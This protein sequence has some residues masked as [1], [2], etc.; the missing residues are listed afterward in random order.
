M[1]TV[2]VVAEP[3]NGDDVRIDLVF[4]HGLSDD[5]Q[6]TWK[7]DGLSWIQDF[8]PKDIPHA[9]IFTCGFNTQRGSQKDSSHSLRGLEE[10][11]RRRD[12]K[13]RPVI[14]LAHSLGGLIL[15]A[16]LQSCTLLLQTSTKGIMFFSTP[17]SIQQEDQRTR[18]AS[19]MGSIDYTFD[20]GY[21]AYLGSISEGFS[22]WLDDRP[23]TG[24]VVCFYERLPITDDLMVVQKESAVLPRCEARG[25]HANHM[26][27]SQFP[28]AS[29][30][31]YQIVLQCMKSMYCLADE[32]MR[33]LL[34]HSLQA[35]PHCRLSKLPTTPDGCEEVI[36]STQ[37][38]PAVRDI[39]RL[40]LIAE[41]QGHYKKAEEKY[42]AAVNSLRSEG[43]CSHAVGDLGGLAVAHGER[44]LDVEIEKK[45]VRLWKLLRS[46]ELPGRDDAAI[47]FCLNKWAC[48]MYGRGR[49]RHAELY[50]RYCLEARIKLYGK[51]SNS[52]LLATANWVSSMMSLGRYQEACNTIRDALENSD[53]TFLNNVSS[54]QVLETFAKL[55]SEC[56]RHELAESILCDVLRKAI[57]LYGYEHPFTLNR[58]SELAAILAHKGNLS[59]AEALSRRCLDGLEQTLGNDH[60]DCLR[61]A[62]RLADYICLQQRY[63]DAIERHKQILTKQRMRIGNQ[64]PETLLTMRSLGI[65]FAL[66]RYWKDAE[67]ILDRALCDLEARLGSDNK[68]TVWAAR[69]LRSVKELHGGQALKEGVMQTDLLKVFG[70]QPNPNPDHEFS[71][72]TYGLS[73]FQTSVEDEVLR[74]VMDRNE[75]KL[76]GVLVKQTTNRQILGRA[77]REAAASSHEPILKLLLGFDAPVNEQSGYH[78]SA[79]QAASLAGSGAIVKLLLGHDADVNQ[80]G[81]IL[82]NALR[83]AVFGGHEAILC[84]LLGSAPPSGLSQNV[85]NTSIQLALRTEN[86][87]MIDHLIEAGADLNAE[88]KLFGSPL[89]QASFYGQK[90]I[91]K[92][93]LERKSDIN[94]RAGL[95]ASPLQVAIETQNEWAINQLLEAG[96]D[97]SSNSEEIS[98]DGHIPINRQEELAKILLNRLADSLPYRPLSVISGSYDRIQIS[99]SWTGPEPRSGTHH[100]SESPSPVPM[101]SGKAL[102]PRRVSTMKRIFEFKSGGNADGPTKAQSMKKGLMMKPKRTFQSLRRR[103]SM[104]A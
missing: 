20:D 86:K 27:M 62:R 93:L 88:D 94:M 1:R 89:Q 53:L 65:D 24:R 97:I 38:T 10:Y 71:N 59:S 31:N 67:M 19:V 57:H 48:L 16:F 25:L 8:V 5:W 75:E 95:L 12:H 47:L 17:N 99:T 37:G 45:F 80:E 83:A 104:L 52:T 39:A 79:L 35:S 81:G 34:R 74:A 76:K 11:E 36:V 90:E 2:E 46:S 63:D 23:F 101:A 18:F 43:H 73:P 14:F 68:N 69:A 85:L 58:V 21:L 70:P 29:D 84:L 82:G 55:A 28:S 92:M 22:A 13:R 61:A 49:Y 51:G 72:Y 54:V 44:D 32:S 103:L 4:V 15:Q 26:N 33:V 100:D 96:A 91:I 30:T 78:G 102:Q 6:F 64:H 87:A 60:P 50:S 56:G 77:L 66:H 40:A 98:P 3:V 7:K 41:D 9:R 42:Q